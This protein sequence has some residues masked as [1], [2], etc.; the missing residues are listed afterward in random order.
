MTGGD[1]RVLFADIVDG[2]D[3]GALR[4]LDLPTLLPAVGW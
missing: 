2:V 3:T 4:R 1:Q